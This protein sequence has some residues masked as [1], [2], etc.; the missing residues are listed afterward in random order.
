MK[1]TFLWMEKRKRFKDG[2]NAPPPLMNWRFLLKYILYKRHEF[3]MWRGMQLRGGRWDQKNSLVVVFIEEVYV[4]KKNLHF[5]KRSYL[6]LYKLF[7]YY[8]TC[9][10]SKELASFSKELA[11]LILVGLLQTLKENIKKKRQ[12]Y[13]DDKYATKLAWFSSISRENDNRTTSHM[14]L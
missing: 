12:K 9:M 14:R 2:K 10:I 8:Q 4:N 1:T 6:Y 7:I 3:F 13:K 11:A 5:C